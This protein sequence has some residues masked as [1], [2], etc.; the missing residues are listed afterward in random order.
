MQ[1]RTTFDELFRSGKTVLKKPRDSGTAQR[2]GAQFGNAA[3]AMAAASTTALMGG[4]PEAA[5]AAAALGISAAPFRNNVLAS[6]PVQKWMEATARR[7]DRS[8]ITS[9]PA[10]ISASRQGQY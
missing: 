9:L 5:A 1:G 7:G 3:P 2:L 4:G 10:A 8:G 6:R